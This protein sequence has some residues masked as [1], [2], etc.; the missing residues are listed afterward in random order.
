MEK[1]VIRVFREEKCRTSVLGSAR[2]GQ[3]TSQ[4]DL[5]AMT[6]KLGS[7]RCVHL[8]PL[9]AGVEKISGKCSLAYCSHAWIELAT[10]ATRVSEEV[11]DGTTT[12][13]FWC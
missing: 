3:K 7:S 10:E 6:S 5:H 12:F 8:E 9:P 13:P 4:S 11:S 2:N 1:G